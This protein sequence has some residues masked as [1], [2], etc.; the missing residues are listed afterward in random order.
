MGVLAYVLF[1]VEENDENKRLAEA[2]SI[3]YWEMFAEIKKERKYIEEASAYYRIPVFTPELVD[4]SGQEV[5]LSG[6]FLPYSKVDSVIIIS[7]Y[8]NASCF[9]CGLAGIESV[10]MVELGKT[11][12]QFRTDQRLV[13]RGNLLLNSTDVKKLAFVISKASVEE[14]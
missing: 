14:L 7:R 10:A 4:L 6:Y 3:D 5:T 8:P 11:M 1:N 2:L 12:K 9:F 13:V